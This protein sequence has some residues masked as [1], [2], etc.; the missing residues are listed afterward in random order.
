MQ[1]LEIKHPDIIFT[2]DFLLREFTR[3]GFNKISMSSLKYNHI[4]TYLCDNPESRFFRS[5]KIIP[6]NP[7]KQNILVKRAPLEQ[8]IAEYR[9]NTKKIIEESK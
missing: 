1:L 4:A 7:Q 3:A 5:T 2:E 9:S 6:P 8:I